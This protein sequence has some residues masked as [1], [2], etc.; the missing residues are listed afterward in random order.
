L[1]KRYE[2][3]FA[4]YK[5]RMAK[6]VSFHRFRQ[7]KAQGPQLL[8]NSLRGGRQLNPL[9]V[10]ARVLLMPPSP[11][12]RPPVTL[13]LDIQ[14]YQACQIAAELPVIRPLPTSPKRYN[15]RIPM[16]LAPTTRLGPYEIVELIGSGG[17]GEVYKARDTRLNRIVA[18]KVSSEQFSERFEGEAHAVAALNHSHICTLHDVG[19]NY[20]VME[21][22]E[23]TTLKGPMPVAQALVYAAQICDALDAAHRKGIIHRDLKPGNILVTKSGIK[24]L[25]FGLAKMLQK[26]RPLDDAT[27]SKALTG[28]NEIVGTLYYMSPEQLQ[29]QATGQE[30]DPRSDI[31]SFGLV[32]YE[33][34]TGK[35]AFDGSSPATVIAA[36]MERPAPS[37]GNVAPSTLDRVLKRC[38]EKDPENRWQNARDL[39][40]ELEWIAQGPSDASAGTPSITRSA[41]LPWVA[42]AVL[43]FIAAAALWIVYRSSRP[44]ELKPLVRLDVDLG[45]DVALNAVGGSDVII[46]PDGTRIAYLTH[47]HIFT[48]KLDQ[49]NAT[50]LSVT[51]GAISPFFSPDSQWVGFTANGKLRKISVEGGSEIVLCDTGASFTGADWGEDGNIVI[52]LRPN[53][54]LSRVSAG[55][56]TPVPITQLQGDELTHRWPQILPGGK[57]ILFTAHNSLT[58]YSDAHIDVVTLSDSHRKTLQRGAMFGRYIP[59]S[60]GKGYLTY[61]NRGTLFAV[62]FDLATLETRGVPVPVLSQVSYTN[63]FGSAKI[64][65]AH[66]GTLIYRSS[67]MDNSQMSI[68]WL[69]SSGKTQPLL[70]RSGVFQ[71]PR[72]SPDGEH[73]A[74]R[75]DDRSGVGIWI[76]D[77]RRD[78][79]APLAVDPT[80]SHPVWTPDGKYVVYGTSHGL[81][82]VR[83]D[84]G[85]K[86]KALTQSK[87]AQYPASFTG[88]G[89]RLAFFQFVQQATQGPDIWTLSVERD[90][91]GL[92]A[93]TSEA[94]L[95]TP[96]AERDPSFSPDGRWLAYASDESG[97][98]EVYVRAFPDKGG[99]WQISS[100]GGAAPIFARNGKDLFFYD[101]PGDRIMRTSYAAKGDAFLAEKPRVWSEHSLALNLSGSVGGQY[102]VAPD[103]KRI[104]AVFPS[105][106]PDSGH[107]IFLENFIDELQRK[108]PL[109][110]K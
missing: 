56:G 98:Y 110:D 36:I 20:L 93:G 47:G 38:L 103:A 13:D 45:R 83:A 2:C 39:K 31:F 66:T 32:L 34:I 99:R 55:G 48:R 54:G 46:S 108:I 81:F 75:S 76:Y 94:F 23:G 7:G 97:M 44:P 87:D 42:V 5:I 80:A 26:S 18:V 3:L 102:D 84:G 58:G 109:G 52:G 49:S 57:A 90:E 27:L 17:M 88:D 41:R 65:F 96:A 6:G 59:V 100:G 85:D 89:K 71:H 92:K 50:E 8:E 101:V 1:L 40:A 21:Y 67:E 60:E 72:F 106:Q 69:D 15:Y 61:I 107:V 16:P 70:D 86:P 24:L 91:N 53:V 43:A 105:M 68:H 74:V 104:A 30:I 28:K 51:P 11:H 25:D 78:T 14:A 19:P 33:M 9:S 29:A 62:L 4:R 12:I 79:L 35:R 95:Q 82:S 63:L 22:I 64:S 73:L 77:L 37:I 10:L